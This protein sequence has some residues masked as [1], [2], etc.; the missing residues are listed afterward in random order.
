M[1]SIDSNF[2]A[3]T[4]LV[5][6]LLGEPGCAWDKKQTLDS[7]RPH[8][9]EEAYEVVSAIEK[10]DTKNHKEE[11]GDL[12][13]Q[14]VFQAT[15][16][17]KAGHFSIQDVCKDV[18]QKM[19]RRHPHIFG[20][21]VSLSA[22]EVS[23]QWELIKQQET[24]GDNKFSKVLQS[25]P[26]SLPALLNAQKLGE[27]VATVGFDW[28]KLA[29]VREKLNEEITELDEAIKEKTL[30]EIE[31]EL[32]DVLFVLTRMAAKLNLSAELALKRANKRFIKRFSLLEQ[33]A[34]LNGQKLEELD[35]DELNKLWQ[36]AK[37]L[38]NNPVKSF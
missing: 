35:L 19:I 11:L 28:K 32:G 16:Q 13:F 24:I 29:D 21:A 30:D 38:E 7:L 10:K 20:K 3:L 31:H 6:T 25:T 4:Q 12:L 37:L 23:S 36:K 18:T 14:I 27:T 5:E 22:E 8:L 33:E 17:E 9:I 2:V 15:L 34:I 1:N 26:E